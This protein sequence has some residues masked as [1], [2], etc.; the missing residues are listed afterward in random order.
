MRTFLR[1][2]TFLAVIAT[3]AHAGRYPASGTQDFNYVDLTQTLGDGGVFSPLNAAGNTANAQFSSVQGNPTP[4]ARLAK[5]GAN[6]NL[7]AFK[8]S[9]LDPGNA[10]QSFDATFTVKMK[11]ATTSSVPG[12]GWALNFGAI[13]TG[14]GSGNSGFA[15]ANGLVLSFDTYRNTPN[16]FPS[17]D[18][19]ANNT[20]VGSYLAS[21]LPGGEV[22]STVSF[23]LSNPVTNGTTATQGIL[24]QSSSAATLQSQMRTV[25]GWNAVTVTAITNGWRVNRVTNGSYANPGVTY[26]GSPSPGGSALTVTSFQTGTDTQPQIWDIKKDG[27]GFRFDDTFRTVNVHWDYNG[28]DLSY[29]G[30]T[31]F[32]D[33]QVPGF[34]PAAGNRFALT[35][36]SEGGG[37]D[38]LFDSLV[39]STTPEQP[40]AGGLII[41]EFMAENKSSLEDEDMDSPDWIELYNGSATATNLNG[42]KLSNGTATWTFPNTPIAAYGHLVVFASGKSRATNPALYHTN[43]T[44]AKAGGTLSLLNAANATV[45]TYT[46]PNQTE[47]ITYGIKY[48]GGAIGFLDTPTPGAATLFSFIVAP[49]GPAEDVVFSREGGIITGTTPVSITTPLAPSSVVRY[50]TDNTIPTAA[51]PLYTGTLNPATTS[52]FRA[53]VFTPNYLP[54]PVSSRTFLLVDSSLSNYNASGQPFKSHLPLIVLDSFGVSVDSITDSGQPRPHRLTY[55]VVIDK[56]VTGFASITSPTVDFQGRG[57][58]HVRGDSSSGFAQKSYAW[59]TWDNYNNDKKV[60]ILGMPAESDWALYGPYTDKT[61]IRNFIIYSKMRDLHSGANG[62]GMRVKMVEVIY[63]QDLNQP[64]SYNDY[65]GVF[66]LM[67]RIKRGKDRVDIEKLTDKVTD[68]NLITGGY[69]FRRDRASSDGTTALPVGMNSHTPGVLNAAQTTYLTNRINAFNNALNG[70]NFADPVLGYAP[71]IDRDSFIDNWWFVEIAKQIDGYRLSTYFYKDRGANSKIVAAPIWDYNLSLGNAD[72]YFGDQ[73]TGWYWNQEDTYWWARLRQDP[74]YE[75]RNWDRYWEL[76]RGIFKTT[77]ILSYIDQLASIPLNG[78]TTPVGN[79]MTI[80]SGQPSTV[81]NAAMRHYRKFPILGTY[82]WPNGAGYANRIY[83]NSNGNSTTGEIDWMKNWLTQRLNWIDDQ[84]FGTGTTIFRPPNF[85]NYGGNVGSG[86]QLTITPYTGTAPGGYSYATGTIYYTTDGSDPKAGA[87]APTEFT[88]IPAGTACKWLVPAAGNGGTTLTAAAG[89]NQ[90]TTYTDPSNIGNWTTANTGIGYDASPN[91]IYDYNPL[92]GANGNTLTQMRNINATCYM[93]VNF[94]I[95]DQATLDSIDTLKL[96]VKCDDGFRAYINGIA[97]AGLND[98]DGTMTSNPAFAISSGVRD[99]N[100]ALSFA[101]YDVTTNGKPALRVGNNVLAIH[102]LNGADATSSDLIMVPKLTYFPTGGAGGSGGIAYT[103]PITLGASQ[104]VKARLLSGATWSP[105]TTAAFVVNAVPAGFGDNDF[106]YVELM[107]VGPGNVDLTGCKLAGGVNFSFDVA[108]PGTLTLAPGQR[109]LAVG[110]VAGFNSRYSPGVGTKIAGAF[111][112][113]L[114]NGGENF[115][116]L[117]AANNV[118]ASVTYGIAAPWPVEANTLGYSLVLNNPVSGTT[119]GAEKWRIGAQ[120]GGTPGQ[121]AGPVFAGNPNGDTDGDGYSD[122]LEYA[123]GN[124]QGTAG[125]TN[126][127]TTALTSY[128]VATVTSPYLTFSY[129]RNNAA[130][131]VNYFVELSTNLTSWDSTPAAVTYVGTVVNG[132]GTSTITHRATN[133]F[134]P[135]IPQF[136]RLRVA[137]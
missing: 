13:P 121:P 35:A 5:T 137:P 80:A 82:V 32:T 30:A 39:F 114:S 65:R 131:G 102:C 68:P 19:I 38:T 36:S 72:Y 2:L 133:P 59:E 52:T 109:I 24:S 134:N 14:E 118:I 63:N 53:R 88:L 91:G 71:Y 29:D 112:G 28:L 17:I 119:Y 95:P 106:E 98:T 57:G 40:L 76:R 128:T 103:G 126:R 120:P 10:I 31:I 101:D 16:D 136:M 94:T 135:A 127:P 79:N 41:S 6:A 96:G 87:V 110:N 58:T 122:Y 117:D 111:G 25:S 4:F 12:G 9:D 92:I 113:S 93:R 86:T 77:S 97:V 90:W 45:S 125:T 60:S 132:D 61:F 105:I 83:Y 100:L 129:R 64:I 81:E 67:E 7:A 130:D 115:T 21:G 51:S 55:G 11:R 42:Y 66:V 62:F 84:N 108:D 43:F 3:S 73:P 34:I 8:V 23:Q 1:T 50:T 89:A 26:V 104:T 85:S 69:I 33:L 15:M 18:V 75:Q 99:E 56:D 27:P 124:P 47:D 123:L 74:N 107:N 22:L 46:Y 49:N 78:S 37:Q 20:A 70:A 54:G 116:V 48:Q 44:L